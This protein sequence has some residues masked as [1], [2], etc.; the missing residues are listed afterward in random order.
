MPKARGRQRKEVTHTYEVRP[1][2]I[3]T[4]THYVI[5]KDGHML[6]TPHASRD[7]VNQRL[8]RIKAKE[9]RSERDCLRCVRPFISEGIHNR[10]CDE[11][12]RKTA[13]ML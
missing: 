4:R 6:G 12:L 7:A 1:F 5:Y 9:T 8:V 3:G 10:L 11:C 2:M 13:T